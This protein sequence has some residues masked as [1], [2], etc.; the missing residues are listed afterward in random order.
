MEII[1]SVKN[2]ARAVTNAVESATKGITDVVSGSPSK[3]VGKGST[4][5]GKISLA[6]GDVN[7]N[8]GKSETMD[9]NSNNS[10]DSSISTQHKSSSMGKISLAS[11]DI[12][13]SKDISNIDSSEIQSTNSY[14]K[15]GLEYRE[16]YDSNGEKIRTVIYS[17]DTDVV[18]YKSPDGTSVKKIKFKPFEDF[19]ND[20]ASVDSVSDAL[21][22]VDNCISTIR[23][24]EDNAVDSLIDFGESI[25]DGLALAGN[26]P[27]SLISRN[28]TSD[29]KG[30][31][32]E[33]VG[34]FIEKDYSSEI[35]NNFWNSNYGK[36]EN[37]KSYIKHDDIYST[38]EKGLIEVAGNVGLDFLGPTG[39]VNSVI[40]TVGHTGENSL[41]DG[42][43]Y[44]DAQ[45]NAII[46]GGIDLGL[47]LIPAHIE[48]IKNFFKDVPGS[49][50]GGFKKVSS[51]FDDIHLP[52][53]GNKTDNISEVQ[54]PSDWLQ[55]R[56]LNLEDYFFGGNYSN[57]I[58]GRHS[59][60]VEV[61]TPNSFKG[62]EADGSAI[63]SGVLY[64]ILNNIDDIS[65]DANYFDIMDNLLSDGNFEP[66]AKEF[67][68]IIYRL[69]EGG[70]KDKF[71]VIE[72]LPNKIN[73]FQRQQRLDFL[74]EIANI[75]SKLKDGE[76]SLISSFD[77]DHFV[78]NIVN[79]DYIQSL[80][81][82]V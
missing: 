30:I 37:E 40:S 48:D 24:L 8:T 9:F 63:H 35:N 7:A 28:F 74:E 60:A 81:K 50:Q 72:Y 2:I 21:E 1:K 54:M 64:E 53:L 41:K 77:S 55:P 75:N 6:S 42:G 23:V 36:T 61:I 43:T 12:D 69:L 73:S 80:K 47:S 82:G 78:E 52:K 5:I 49:I 70:E 65:K 44:N 26:M 15:D 51:L 11:G 31:F 33:E 46:F 25:L 32:D 58:R 71:V 3:N 68:T 62:L 13:I 76:V 10:S 22:V 27:I 14:E 56:N 67:N 66:V 20:V 17:P 4:S 38:V 34:A 18:E 16:E 45:N 59:I 79:N 39:I 19:S 29:N 57:Y